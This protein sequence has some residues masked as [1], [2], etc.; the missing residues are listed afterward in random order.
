MT[1]QSYYLLAHV[2][3]QQGLEPLNLYKMYLSTTLGTTCSTGLTEILCENYITQFLNYPKAPK[4]FYIRNFHDVSKLQDLVQRPIVL[5]YCTSLAK[6]KSGKNIKKIFDTRLTHFMHNSRAAE[7]L[8]YLLTIEDKIV[9]LIGQNERNNGIEIES[10]FIEISQKQSSTCCMLG[11]IA[12]VLCVSHDPPCSS[13]L[14][15]VCLNED[16]LVS[17]ALN[18]TRPVALV[19]HVSTD[20]WK[21]KGQELFLTLGV[22]KNKSLDKIVWSDCV[23]V[24]ITPDRQWV[25]KVKKCVVNSILKSQEECLRNYKLKSEKITFSEQE[26][27]RQSETWGDKIKCQCKYCLRAR[28]FTVK[29]L[30]KGPQQLHKN[31]LTLFDF[32]KFFNMNTQENRDL[33]LKCCEYSMATVDFECYSRESDNH[34]LSNV[35]RDIV[36]DTKLGSNNVLLLSQKPVLFA[37]LDALGRDEGQ[38]HYK[39][40]HVPNDMAFTEAMTKYL[41]HLFERKHKLKAQKLRLLKKFLLFV[42]VAKKTHFQFLLEKDK[43]REQIAQSF[44]AGLFG[45]FETNLYRLINC[46]KVYSFNGTAYDHIL[47]ARNLVT[48]LQNVSFE[49]AAK[50]IHDYQLECNRDKEYF[51]D[52]PD[53]EETYQQHPTTHDSSS[54]SSDEQHDDDY[55]SSSAA[56]LI[57][58]KISR[59]GSLINN[60]FLVE[61]KIGFFDVKKFLPPNATL[62]SLAKMTGCQESKGMFPFERLT[63][64]DYLVNTTQLPENVMAWGSRLSD[65]IPSEED[66]RQCIR[67]FQNE[68]H[69]NLL[70][71]LEKYL[72]LDVRLLLEATVKVFDSFYRLADCHPIVS[73]KN[74]LSSFSSSSLQSYL[75]NQKSPGLFVPRH[76]QIYSLLKGAL[77]GGVS[78]VCRTDGGTQPGE[79]PINAHLGYTEKAKKIIASDEN[80]LYGSSGKHFNT[81]FKK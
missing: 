74:S 73:G 26:R 78:L 21:N 30:S 71:Y 14:L 55:S 48:A 54:C 15:A 6:Y 51:Y 38:Y 70:S 28:D 76:P 67:D 80:T 65:K 49:S 59:E 41:E 53:E 19:S 39:V 60:I 7:P 2:A 37:H 20:V 27:R 1:N 9:P 79:E 34:P 58:V 31:P 16:G 23:Y 45:Q 36:T 47:L 8:F 11:S 42:S 3:K 56:P 29:Q 22:L 5:L 33:I 57:R 43:S 81:F 24:A 12:Q 63:S 62:A 66:V 32:L 17:K 4:Y 40:F 10:K 77:L 25:Y 50:I 44:R 68:C 64:Y 61:A 46:L 18:L 75:M 72:I 35:P 52:N 13:D 69:P